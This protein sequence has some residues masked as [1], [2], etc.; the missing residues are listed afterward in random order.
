M[1]NCT[2]L[3]VLYL[4]LLLISLVGTVKLLYRNTLFKLRMHL[5]SYT[6]GLRLL[7]II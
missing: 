3:N 4:G 6:N 5:R 1:F 7:L 2:F